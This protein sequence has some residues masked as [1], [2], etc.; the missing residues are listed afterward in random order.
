MAVAA[1]ILG[2]MGTLLAISVV[3]S[4]LN[5]GECV[6]DCDV[7]NVF[8]AGVLVIEGV[9]SGLLGSLA[10]SLGL[11]AHRSNRSRGVSLPVTRV[12]ILLGVAALLIAVGGLIG[13]WSSLDS[14]GT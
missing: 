9:L 7:I 6:H 5:P 4:V 13:I 12:A 1:L 3:S 2:L 11:A 8:A 10:F 14:I